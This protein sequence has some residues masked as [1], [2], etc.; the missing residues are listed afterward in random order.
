MCRV[1]LRG[2]RVEASDARVEPFLG[3]LSLVVGRA[4]PS[5]GALM[6]KRVL[7]VA[8]AAAV[9][10]ASAPALAIAAVLIKLSSPGPAIFRQ[11]RVG[12]NG[13]RFTVYKLRTMVEGAEQLLPSFAHRN[14]MSGPAFKD[15]DDARVTPIGRVLRRFSLDEL[16]QL[17]NVLQGDMSLVGPR[18]LPVHEAVAISD[19]Y[20][21][22]FR[23]KPGLTCLWQVSGRNDVKFA[24]WMKYDLDYVDG[25]SLW[26]DTKLLLKT[27]PVI[28]SGRGAY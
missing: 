11:T 18:P 26:L 17:V 7:D 2:S 4:G 28:V 6:A 15:P 25:W 16:P 5:A 23:M 3:E 19:V 24:E 1:L 9:L 10:A 14:V 12:L 13:R 21:R 8:L 22:R 27:I 20:R